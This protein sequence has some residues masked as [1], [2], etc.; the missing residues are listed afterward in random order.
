[1]IA[2]YGVRITNQQ[3]HEPSVPLRHFPQQSGYY[4][5]DFV[6]SK[7]LICWTQTGTLEELT[8]SADGSSMTGTWNGSEPLTGAKIPL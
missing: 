8:I 1:M 5:F 7:V 6:S 4:F 3:N 2:G